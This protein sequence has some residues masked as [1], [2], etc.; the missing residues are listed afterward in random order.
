MPTN[1]KQLFAIEQKNKQ[2]WL[3]VNPALRDVSGIYVLTRKEDDIKYAY[4]GQAVKILS[5]LASHLIG[6]QHI[7]LSLK[8]HGLLSYDNPTG[9]NVTYTE[10]PEYELDKQEQIYIKYYANMGYQLRNKTS[11]SQGEGKKGIADNKPSRG[12]RDG[13]KQGEKNIKRELNKI[14]NK[15]LVIST[16]VD[17][18]LSQ[19]M[20]EKFY[21]ILDEN[22]KDSE[23][24]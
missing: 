19:R 24:A 9:W 17:N 6:Y 12:Y 2:K 1:Y 7:D 4:I 3:K 14:I 22:E 8:K 23:N 18:K 5:R 16:K 13:I 15:Y 20:L 21:E 10:F 11:G